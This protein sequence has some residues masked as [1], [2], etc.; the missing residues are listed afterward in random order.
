[1]KVRF[2]P[3]CILLLLTFVMSACGQG[4]E[5]DLMAE[6]ERYMQD[7]NYQGAIV[8]FKTL[9]EKSPE[10]MEARFALGKAYLKTGKLDQAEKSFEK[11]AR[12]NP[13]DNELL[14]ET[15]RLKLFR[16]DFAGAVEDLTTYTDKEPKSAEG[17]SLLGR[18]EWALGKDKEA[19]AKF[20]KALAL[21]PNQT[22]A[23]LALAQ[24]YLAQD[25]TAK[26]QELIDNLLAVSPNNREGLYFKARLDGLRGDQEGYLAT[27]KTLVNA[28]PTDGYAKFLYGK[29]LIGEGDLD[30]A[31]ALSKELLEGAPK[32]P[33]G[34]LLAGLVNYARKDY[35][36]AVNALQEAV[37]I[38][39][40]I[41]GYFYLGMSYYGMGDLETA[42]SQLRIAADRSDR[43]LKAREMISLILFQQKRYNEAI[44]EAQKIIEVDPNNVLGRVILGDAYTAKGNPDMALDELKEI[45]E[46][47]PNFANAFIKMGALYYQ[48]GEMGETEAALKGAMDAA[49]D[50]VRP[51]LV[52]SAFYLRNGDKDLAQGILTKGLKGTQEDVPLYV[53]LARMSLLDKDTAKA[54]EYLGKAKSLDEKNPA[55]FMMLASMDLAE[56]NAE[57]ALSEYNA[58]IAQRPAYVRAL[59]AKAVVLDTMGKNDEAVATYKEAI[60]SGDASAYMAYAGSLRKAG[61]DEGALGVINEGLDRFVHN[62]GLT[63]QKAE[64]L[65]AMKRY[66]DVLTMSNEVEKVNR[67]AGLSLRTRTYVLMKEYD[68]AVA[69]ARQM[70]DFDPKNPSGYLVL[71]DVN[72]NAG[73]TD[74]WVKALDEGVAKC[75][76]NPALLLQLGRY[77][78]S[79]GDYP[80]ALTYFDS[81]IKSDEKS[82]QAYAMQGDVYLT[83]GRKDKA[84][85]SYT[86]ALEL[87]DRYIP[88]L[89]NLAMIYI[90]D[91]KTAPEALRLAYKAYL[92]APWNPSIMDTFGY[93]LAV[94]GKADT[95][96]SILEKAASVQTDDQNINYHLGYAYY[97]AGDKEKA[98]STLKV[99]ADCPECELRADARKLIKTID[100]E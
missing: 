87:N 74:A 72:M 35:T 78:S 26:A 21:D 64:I 70:C 58:L 75:G 92:Q 99:V 50:S 77:Y 49:P 42:I 63:Q 18:A 84:V 31:A 61:N 40:D 28:H 73:R 29:A 76:P 48:K 32:A 19:M 7:E 80:K 30:S 79:Q 12:Q 53:A 60:K 39:P 44:A 3:I 89:N 97:K 46:K 20:E 66:D 25:D 56:K 93:A 51:R 34:K 86:R 57:G 38:R 68:K 17:F 71:A 6:G 65:Y 23:E 54:R 11:Y 88:A 16:R 83:T 37:S 4:S 85:D 24:L 69:A 95:A 94:N 91:S 45:T 43:F 33:F 2:A 62:T 52:L 96:V 67:A 10:K 27:L 14:L 41:E 82:F 15:G 9:L 81:V 1:M 8:I 59:L 13:Y 36:A 5:S 90:N 55:P 47:N 22:E 98:K 100:G